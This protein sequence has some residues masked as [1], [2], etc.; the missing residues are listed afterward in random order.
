MS[1]DVLRAEAQHFAEVAARELEDMITDGFI[2]DDITVEPFGSDEG[3]SYIVITTS[4]ELA[5]SLTKRF[6]NSLRI[7]KGNQTR[8]VALIVKELQPKAGMN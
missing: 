7:T 5:E 3:A 1:A 4:S 2:M 6:S 8:D